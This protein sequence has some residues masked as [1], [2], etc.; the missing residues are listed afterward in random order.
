MTFDEVIRMFKNLKLKMKLISIMLALGLI[1][2]MILGFYAVNVAQN[3]IH[4]ITNSKLTVY[5]TQKRQSFENWIQ[6]SAAE[7]KVLA[8]SQELYKSL[9]NLKLMSWKTDSPGGNQQLGIINTYLTNSALQMGLPGITLINEKGMIIYSTQGSDIGK[10]QSQMS[11][12]IGAKQGAISIS[13]IYYSDSLNDAVVNVAVPVLAAGS[14]G[15]VIGVLAMTAQSADINKLLDSG[16]EDIGVT[17]NIYLIDS[18]AML[19]T[20]PKFGN[21]MPFKDKIATYAAKILTSKL[22]AGEASFETA[23]EYKN[24]RGDSVIGYYGIIHMGQNLAG[25]IVEVESSEVLGAIG[26]LRNW[27]LLFCLISM[28]VIIGVSWNFAH[29]VSKPITHSINGLNDST[30]QLAATAK[31]LS[32]SSQQLSQ[33]SAEQATSIEETS[34]T[35]E[36]SASMIQQNSIN[37]QEAVQLSGDTK[38]A[39]EKGNYEMDEMMKS[40]NEIKKSSDQIAK[41]IKVIDDIAFQT[42]ILALNAAIEAARAGEAGMGFAV[43]A[44][45]VRNLAQRSAQ[46]AKDTTA[47]IELNIELS[48]KGVSITERVREALNEI[49]AQ[50]KK[51]SELMAEISVASQ[52]QSQG[53]EEVNKAIAQMEKVIQQNAANAEENA[54]SSENL[55]DQAQILREIVQQLFELVNGK[56]GAKLIT[57]AKSH[58]SLDHINQTEKNNIFQP[59]ADQIAVADDEQNKLLVGED[60]GKTVVVTPE[61]IIPLEKKPH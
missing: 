24:Y 25:I 43:V 58:S 53:I 7:L 46:A 15:E 44:E 18:S 48:G 23:S 60:G 37:I 52:E 6:K 61:D 36:E 22:A 20:T 47:M 59:I 49:T 26:R 42:N 10:D 40:M 16:I 27:I 28:I 8:T 39:A 3:E 11:Y 32:A 55:S 35:L 9:N 1:P 38:Q 13:N 57:Y 56:A 51:V 45:E 14:R 2:L 31:Q 41:I 54:S 29:S 19:I 30:D 4:Q 50:A 17:G 34:S 33:G 12:F 21:L 5:G